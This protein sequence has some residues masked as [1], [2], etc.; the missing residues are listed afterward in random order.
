MREAADEMH[1]G[2]AIPNVSSLIMSEQM[3]VTNLS[4][5]NLA[6]IDD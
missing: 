1:N 5:H 2:L 6:G 4:L 3:V